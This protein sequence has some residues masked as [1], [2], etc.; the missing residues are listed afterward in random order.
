MDADEHGKGAN[1]YTLAEI[2]VI[3]MQPFFSKFLVMSS[4]N[5]RKIGLLSLC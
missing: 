4:D 5:K 3:T 1:L 2:I